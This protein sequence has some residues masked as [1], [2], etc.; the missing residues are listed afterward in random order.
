ML[1]TRSNACTFTKAALAGRYYRTGEQAYIDVESQVV[2]KKTPAFAELQ[3]AKSLLQQTAMMMRIQ[4]QFDQLC[5]GRGFARSGS[6]ANCVGPL[7]FTHETME[8]FIS[9]NTGSALGSEEPKAQR[10]N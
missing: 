3:R 2:E 5:R 10:R 7:M 9:C 1:T 6:Q 4:Q 8:L